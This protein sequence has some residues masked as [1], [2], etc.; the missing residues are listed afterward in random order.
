LLDIGPAADGTI[1]VIMQQRLLE[2]GKWLKVNGEAI[3]NTNAFIKTKKDESIN[4]ETNKT[5]F[6]TQK[7]KDLYVICLD[8]P[9][10][11]ITLSNIPENKGVKVAL[12]GNKSVVNVKSAGKTLQIIA[13][14]LTPDDYQSA[15]VFRVSGLIR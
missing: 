3:Y 2:I 11:G 15:Y 8:W 14:S 13:P 5:V 9:K 6:F 10:E 4:P 1:P 7:G 12:M